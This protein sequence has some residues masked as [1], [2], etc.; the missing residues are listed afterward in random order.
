M[1]RAARDWTWSRRG[2]TLAQRLVLLALAEYAGERGE[3]CF[4]SLGLLERMSEPSRRGITKALGGPDGTLIERARGGP[5]S[6]KTHSACASLTE[7]IRTD[8]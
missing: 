5:G 8:R 6:G 3:Q 4:P 1:S 2:L 7:V